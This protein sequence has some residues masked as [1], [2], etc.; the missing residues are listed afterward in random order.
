MDL[1]THEMPLGDF[2]RAYWPCIANHPLQWGWYMDA[3]VDHLEASI[4]GDI[5]R[6]LITCPP[7]ASRS[8]L[9]SMFLPAWL[10]SAPVAVQDRANVFSVAATRDLAIRNQVAA[11]KIL[12]AARKG[13]ART[14]IG[15]DMYMPL[16]IHAPITGMRAD[17]IVFDAPQPAGLSARTAEETTRL[18][19]ERQCLWTKSYTESRRIVITKTQET[20]GIAHMARGLGYEELRIPALWTGTH[21]SRV[22]T[23]WRDP[24]TQVGESFMPSLYSAEELAR[25]R[26]LMGHDKF[27]A[28]YQQRTLK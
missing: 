12:V 16:S 2:V 23:G 9:A 13:A 7:G 14:G 11:D 21:Q 8:T 10:L 25:L 4:R 28:W 6:L 17:V 1:P 19:V 26:D 20:P 27:E 22:S 5:P 24:R 15:R 18:F 3:I